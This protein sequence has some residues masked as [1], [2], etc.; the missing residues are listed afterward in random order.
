[1]NYTLSGTATNGV[2]FEQ[3]SGSVSLSS[4]SAY[5]Q[6]P[7]R[8]IDDTIVEGTE[9]ATLTITPGDGYVVSKTSARRPD[10]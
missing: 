5:V 9:T 7:V 3:L 4:N 10:A 2:D 6:I 8:P 1:M